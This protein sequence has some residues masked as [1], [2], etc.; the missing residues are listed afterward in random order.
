MTDAFERGSGGTFD[1][2]PELNNEVIAGKGGLLK[3]RMQHDVLLI[4]PNIDLWLAAFAT[5]NETSGDH[6]LTNRN[7]N[8]KVFELTFQG[9]GDFD[10]QIQHLGVCVLARKN[11]SGRVRLAAVLSD[12]QR[13]VREADINDE[14]GNVFF[15][16]VAPPSKSIDKLAVDGSE[17]SGDYVLLDDFGF[18]V[19]NPSR[20]GTHR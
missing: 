15:S 3:L 14:S 9:E 19:A 2:P 7:K 5:A 1:I 10:P 17:F 20:A 13:I 6:L 8:E 16:W 11:Q 12:G 4:N 18:I